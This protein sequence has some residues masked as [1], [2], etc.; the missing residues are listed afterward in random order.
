MI[1]WSGVLSNRCFYRCRG[2]D[3]SATNYLHEVTYKQDEI[4]SSYVLTHN[5][6]TTRAN[7]T[8]PT[9]GHDVVKQCRDYCIQGYS[10]G[11]DPSNP[12]QTPYLFDYAKR[13]VLCYDIECE[14]VKSR[15]CIKLA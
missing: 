5:E 14:F 9:I 6:S 8:S 15:V 3:G 7:G 4:T 11:C 12:T 1:I 2:D 13:C 10:L